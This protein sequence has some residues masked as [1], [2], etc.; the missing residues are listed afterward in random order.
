MLNVAESVRDRVCLEM[1]HPLWSSSPEANSDYSRYL[2]LFA[3]ID[4]IDCFFVVLNEHPELLHAYCMSFV[5]APF[6]LQCDSE[7]SQDAVL[8]RI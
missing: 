6:D 4:I 5:S 7:F 3:E 1:M 2:Q 8:E